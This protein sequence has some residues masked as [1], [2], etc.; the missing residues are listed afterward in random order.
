MARH[1]AFFWIWVLL[2]PGISAQMIPPTDY[3]PTKLM[4]SERVCSVLV[5]HCRYLEELLIPREKVFLIVKGGLSEALSFDTKGRLESRVGYMADTLIVNRLE[6]FKY[7]SL[8][9]IKQKR[10]QFFR[11]NGGSMETEDHFYW[12]DPDG[13]LER[14]LLKRRSRGNPFL[15]R[16]KEETVY[17]Y[18]ADKIKRI[19][20]AYPDP[21][22]DPDRNWEFIYKDPR[23][24]T[25]LEYYQDDRAM[26]QQYW[27]LFPDAQGRA[28]RIEHFLAA[29]RQSNSAWTRSYDKAGHI[30][31]ESETGS[32]TPGSDLMGA[33]KRE[34][35]YGPKGKL[36]R[37]I[38]TFENGDRRIVL[39]LYRY[40]GDG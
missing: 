37:S 27:K 31:Q 4:E 26:V 28:T 25:V 17:K 36:L 21:M 40:H 34:N 7:D 11:G 6:E 32:P 24:V 1:L 10:K 33:Q 8:N 3:F 22:E 18:D 14:S 13:K 9:R 16:N 19:T 29:A 2:C 15:S 5:M 35:I 30:L 39:F 23:K 38:L 12:Y 20:T